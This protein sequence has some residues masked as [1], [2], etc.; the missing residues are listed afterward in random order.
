MS[1]I[2]GGFAAFLILGQLVHLNKKGH[3]KEKRK[4]RKQIL[5]EK[6]KVNTIKSNAFPDIPFPFSLGKTFNLLP[7]RLQYTFCSGMM[8]NNIQSPTFAF[9]DESI[10]NIEQ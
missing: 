7:S 8:A 2:I 3:K 6:L 5:E 9:H 4:N 10:D 1:G